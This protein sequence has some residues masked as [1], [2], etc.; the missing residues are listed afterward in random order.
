MI[1]LEKTIE[2]IKLGRKGTGSFTGLKA[3]DLIKVSFDV[4][5]NGG[6]SPKVDVYINGVYKGS[7]FARSFNETLFCEK[8]S[9]RKGG[10]VTLP[11]TIK[12]Y[13]EADK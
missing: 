4:D 13:K 9:W 5:G 8:Q 1:T 2:V 7:P 11:P 10:Y 3:G 6:N 12:E